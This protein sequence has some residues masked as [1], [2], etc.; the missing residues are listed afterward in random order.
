VYF[1][2]RSSNISAFKFEV[3]ILMYFNVRSL[4]LVNFNVRS[5]NISAFKFE[6][7]I[8]VHFNVRSFNVSAF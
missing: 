1:N 2:V 3:V 5:F 8:L 7:L 4:I 6:V